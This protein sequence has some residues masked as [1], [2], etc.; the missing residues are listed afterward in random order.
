MVEC[1]IYPRGF[2]LLP[3]RPKLRLGGGKRGVIRGSSSS[4]FRRLRVFCL[5]HDVQLESFGVT[6]TI[7]G[8]EIV[9]CEQFKE[10]FHKLSVWLNYHHVPTIWRVEL[11]KR[12][13]PHI[14]AVLYAGID[15]VMAVVSEWYK[16]L[17]S[18]NTCCVVEIGDCI[19]TI[20]EMPRCYISGARYA[21]DIQKLDGDYRSYR[22]L[23][24]H[25]S[26]SKQAQL[27]YTGRN[28]GVVNRSAF[29]SVVPEK[30]QIPDRVYSMIL[31]WLRR[32]TR[33]KIN[34]Y[35]GCSH[36]VTSP[37]TFRRLLDY[38]KQ[39]NHDQECHSSTKGKS[40]KKKGERLKG[41]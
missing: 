6:F 18:E 34:V 4:S 22:Y 10:M 30:E 17:E 32:L 35:S 36:W 8:I 27:G 7:P 15:H 1:A 20:A 39:L 25:M 29:K 11:Q 37:T 24:S 38:A 14:H 13:M 16:I 12:K 9:N 21:V 40:N 31:R 26:K 33:R 23:I 3:Q 19:K 41:A 2:S 28:W 5:T